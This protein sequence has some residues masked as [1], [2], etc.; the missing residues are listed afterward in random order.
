LTG[1]L[2]QGRLVW[3]YAGCRYLGVFVGD[4]GIS[5]RTRYVAQNREDPWHKGIAENPLSNAPLGQVSLTLVE[6]ESY[7]Q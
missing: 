7:D 3:F 1:T 6:E 5:L 2:R 4:T